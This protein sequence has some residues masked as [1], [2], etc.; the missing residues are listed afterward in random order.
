MVREGKL[1]SEAQPFGGVHVG[2]PML[3]EARQRVSLLDRRGQREV[4]VVQLEAQHSD[5]L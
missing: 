1:G 3:Q 2:G 5:A 4:W